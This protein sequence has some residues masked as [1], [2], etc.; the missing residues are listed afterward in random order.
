MLFINRLKYKYTFLIGIGLIVVFGAILFF[1]GFEKQNSPLEQEWVTYTNE[2][3]GYQISAT[4]KE[5]RILEE[6]LD[7]IEADGASGEQ[8]GGES[9]IFYY[10]D[11]G[12]ARNTLGYISCYDERQPWPELSNDM[13]L[14]E[15]A[16]KLYEIEDS[17][18]ISPSYERKISIAKLH[19]VTLDGKDAYTVVEGK[20]RG[21]AVDIQAQTITENP[22]G[23]KCWIRYSISD[24]SRGYDAEMLKNRTH[25]FNS[26]SWIR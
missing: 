15:Y 1:M 13:P 10:K 2:K 5:G 21:D 4:E 17:L 18:G 23:K 19:Q 25:W 8:P 6:N 11:I 24:H 26:F 16:Q 14:K 7:V 20:I 3:Y 12:I 9:R 22:E